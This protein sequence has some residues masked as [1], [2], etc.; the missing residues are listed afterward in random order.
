MESQNQQNQKGHWKNPDDKGLYQVWT[1]G[2]ERLSKFSDEVAR[3]AVD[4]PPVDDMDI[5]T[6]TTSTT[7][8]NFNGPKWWAIPASMLLGGSLCFA[9]FIFSKSL[10]EK[11]VEK[12]VEIERI[13]EL[14]PRDYEI[15]WHLDGDDLKI[16]DIKRAE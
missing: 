1:A 10:V 8:N 5:K 3:K 7:N 13:I 4:L 15:H 6:E 2:V 14:E 11:S 16:D 9:G 12:S